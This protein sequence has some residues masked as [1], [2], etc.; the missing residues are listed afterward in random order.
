MIRRPP[1]STRTDKLFPYTTLFRSL[2]F[3]YQCRGVGTQGGLLAERGVQVGRAAVL[4][5]SGIPTVQ[6]L[7]ILLLREQFDQ[8]A[9]RACHEGV[10]QRAPLRADRKSTRLNSSH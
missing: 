7:L 4:T 1:I 10:E 2:A 6:L 8:S 5:F 3:E 9:P